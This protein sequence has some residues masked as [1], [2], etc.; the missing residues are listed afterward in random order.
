[1]KHRDLIALYGRRGL[2]ATTF[3][4]ITRIIASPVLTRI[5]SPAAAVAQQ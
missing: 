2:I 3:A 1:M 4:L 5:W